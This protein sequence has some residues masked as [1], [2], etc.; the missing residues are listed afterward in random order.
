MRLKER[1]VFMMVTHGDLHERP[2]DS[3]VA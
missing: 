1:L 2:E 3:V